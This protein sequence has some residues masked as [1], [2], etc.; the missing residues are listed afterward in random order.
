V[1]CIGFVVV[2]QRF[3]GKELYRGV[4]RMHDVLLLE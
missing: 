4:V 1:D 2:F 3:G